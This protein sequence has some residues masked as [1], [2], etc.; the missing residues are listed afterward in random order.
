M[1]SNVND[2]VVAFTTMV[3]FDKSGQDYSYESSE[4]YSGPAGVK[5]EEMEWNDGITSTTKFTIF[6]WLGISLVCLALCVVIC[7]QDKKPAQTQSTTS[8]SLSRPRGAL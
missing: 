2:V 7:W 3:P 4:D 8:R 5:V 6:F 1:F